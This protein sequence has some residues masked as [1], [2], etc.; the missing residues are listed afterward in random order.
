MANLNTYKY[1]HD[2]G[3]PYPNAGDKTSLYA[4][5]EYLYHK[6]ENCT[7]NITYFD[8]YKI[9]SVLNNATEF[10]SKV[11]A[12][13]PYSSMVLN[14]FVSLTGTNTSYN[15]GDIVIKNIDGTHEVI[16]AQRGGIFYPSSIQKASLSDSENFTYDFMFSYQSAEPSIDEIVVEDKNTTSDTPGADAILG[17]PDGI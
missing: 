14:T 2:Y 5:I 11:N 13:P 17:Q 3:L 15:I 16:A 10:E 9:N 4:N 6:I 1:Y 12:L 7:R 8:L